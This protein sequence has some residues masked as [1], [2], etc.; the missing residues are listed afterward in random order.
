VPTDAHDNAPSLFRPRFFAGWLAL[1][2]VLSFPEVLLGFGAFVLRDFSTFGY[3]LA[4]WHK[5]SFWQGELPFWNPLV[6]CGVPHLAQWNTMVFYPGTLI[7]LLL[8]VNVPLAL[9]WFCLAHLYA[10]GLGMY[11]LARYLIQRDFPAA[12]AGLAFAFSGPLQHCLMWPNN[13]AALGLMPWVALTVLHG[14]RVG[15]RSLLWPI[16]VGAGQML[17]GAP[18]MILFTWLLAG[19]AVLWQCAVDPRRDWAGPAR[20]LAGVVVAV[21]GL[22][23]IQLLPFFDLALH[24]L[25]ISHGQEVQW[26][27][28]PT[29]WVNLFLPMAASG[30]F[31]NGVVYLEGQEWINSIYLGLPTLWLGLLALRARRSP[32][33]RMATFAILGCVLL[34]LGPAGLLYSWINHFI[35]LEIVRYPIKFLTPVFFLLPLLAARG[36]AELPGNAVTPGP[37]PRSRWTALAALVAL[38]CLSMWMI[39]TGRRELD[40]GLS[41]LNGLLRLLWLLAAAILLH[42]SIRASGTR[43][44]RWLQL[45]FIV[46]VWWDLKTHLPALAPTVAPRIYQVENEGLTALAPPPKPGVGRLYRLPETIWRT[47]TFTDEGMEMSLLLLRAE[48]A[49]NLNL[50]EGAASIGGFLSLWFPMWEGIGDLLIDRQ[51]RLN[52]E[53]ADFLAI[54][55]TNSRDQFATWL[56]RSGSHPW[57]TA[58]MAPRFA[59]RR[60]AFEHLLNGWWSA[61]AEVFLETRWQEKIVAQADP[62]A[63][64]N[65]LEFAPN[66]IRFEVECA[67]PTM[68]AIAQFHHRWWRATIDGVETPV[69]PANLS[70]QAVAVPAGRHTVE[71]RYVDGW[72]RIGAGISAVTLLLCL[73]LFRRWRP[74]ETPAAPEP[75]QPEAAAQP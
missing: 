4:A 69:M 12:V 61:D 20:R 51:G 21:A 53:L 46:V 47:D 11:F 15:G 39:G 49:E 43:T 28:S 9:S 31:A 68:A 56:R 2:V 54:S 13:I 3:P 70:F 45:G 50:P 34:S 22:C 72:F 18:E 27:A 26:P 30:Q 48:L 67:K 14:C 16:A 17:S 5:T 65:V 33:V 57:I 7:Y 38:S 71:L 42:F 24:S 75:A 66:Q 29:F 23:A 10:G 19:G 1:A 40:P 41:L 59:S 58:G 52:E 55:H 8:P 32:A 60:E 73:F 36:A 64:V 44:R 63:R 37:G 25:R 35:P 62:Q 6:Y 74:I